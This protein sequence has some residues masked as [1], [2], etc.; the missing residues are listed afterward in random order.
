MPK[1]PQRSNRDKI[2]D[3]IIREFQETDFD[4]GSIAYHW[5]RYQK[6]MEKDF[7][8]LNAYSYPAFIKRWNKSG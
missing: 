5:R 7:P 8:E 1:D 3:D 4:G 6:R 2:T